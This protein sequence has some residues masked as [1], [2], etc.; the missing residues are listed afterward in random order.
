MGIL[1]GRGDGWEP[2][3]DQ[4]IILILGK[5]AGAVPASIGDGQIR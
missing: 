1:Q 3:S 5:T 4:E 2:R